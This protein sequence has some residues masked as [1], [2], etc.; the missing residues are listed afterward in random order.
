ML[1]V[2]KIA[3][4]TALHAPLSKDQALGDRETKHSNAFSFI[5]TERDRP[6]HMYLQSLKQTFRIKNVLSLFL[7]FTLSH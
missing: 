6:S 3:F 1:K 4:K 5:N 2:R 7:L